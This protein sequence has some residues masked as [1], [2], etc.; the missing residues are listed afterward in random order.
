LATSCA[1]LPAERAIFAP[2]PGRSSMQWIVVPTGMLRSGR[3]LP[4]LMSAFGPA[5]TVAP[6]RRFCGAMM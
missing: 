3:L 1:E 2:P 6:W 4:G 5:S